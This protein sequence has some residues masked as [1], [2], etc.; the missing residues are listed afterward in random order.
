M[1]GLHDILTSELYTDFID[2]RTVY[3]NFQSV[4]FFVHFLGKV[5]E[6]YLDIRRFLRCSKLL[7]VTVNHAWTLL[8]SA[9]GSVTGARA[10]PLLPDFQLFNFFLVASELQKLLTFDAVWLPIQWKSLQAYN[11]NNNNNHDDIYSAVIMA[12]PLREFTRFTRWIQKRRQVAA[13]LW[14]KPIGW[15]RL[16]LCH[17]LLHE[18]HNVSVCLNIF[19]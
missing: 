13:G 1:N 3:W 19:C 5:W 8:S 2:Y 15:S 16:L 12:E 7:L 10:A 14:T 4:R 9:I 6:T 17:C 18:F 11:N